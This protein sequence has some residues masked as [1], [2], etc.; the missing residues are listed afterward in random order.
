MAM[1][2]INK[3]S[4]ENVKSC[5]KLMTALK[6]SFSYNECLQNVVLV[7]KIYCQSMKFVDLMSN[8]D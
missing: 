1:K 2:N 7:I 8:V 6:L 5:T 3:M 4:L